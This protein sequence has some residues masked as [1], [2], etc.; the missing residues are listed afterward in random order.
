MI[1]Y[2]PQSQLTLEGFQTPFFQHLD[3]NN[4]WVKLADCIPWDLLAN[5][6]YRKMNNDQGAP[7]LS[8]RMVIGAVI[9]KHLLNIDDREVVAQIRENMYLQYFV[10]LSSF[11]TKE[12]FDPSLMV[13]IRYRLGQDVM[14]EFNQ[15]VLQ[16]AGIIVPSSTDI[17]DKDSSDNEDNG[18]DTSATDDQNG[19]TI[20][21]QDDIDPSN[22]KE[23]NDLVA[24][25]IPLPENSGTLL[26]DATVAEQQIEYPTD[27]KLLNESREQLETMI[28]QVCKQVGLRQPRMY[29]NKARQQYLTLAK[30]KKK[31]NKDIRKGLRSQLQYVSRDLKYINKLLEEHTGLKKVLDKKDWKILQVI[32]EVYRQQQQMYNEDKRSIEHRIVS[33]YQPH[34]RPMPRGKDRVQTE[35]GSKQLVMLKDGYAHVHT[36][37]W[38]NFNEGIQLKQCTEAYKEIYGCYPEKI[39]AD[40]IFGNRANREFLKEKEIRFVGKQLGR[41]PKMT[42]AEKRK[43]QK[44]MAGR[45]AIEGKFG[46]G[47]NAY[48][49]QKIKAR[50]K[51]TSESWIM[52]IYFI[53]NL[54]KLSER[55]FLR[56]LKVWLQ[57]FMQA[58]ILFQWNYRTAYKQIL[59]LAIFR[60][61]EK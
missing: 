22:N 49:L 40:A 18:S 43:L 7:S 5:V 11:T 41:P 3:K 10:G 14:E 24:N 12:P 48:G 59:P 35:F 16:Q 29:K 58:V 42:S 15:L 25:K 1:R 45:N 53:M 6:Y 57:R 56:L 19:I 33:L 27:L 52:S 39:S 60:V 26:L 50:M 23:S 38:D 61:G 47:K 28:G 37:S 36:I 51:E 17:D 31:T 4:R 30:K 2:I 54:V 8:A 55:A 44:E 46:Q 32:H 9:I 21:Q 34:V 13:S 20:K